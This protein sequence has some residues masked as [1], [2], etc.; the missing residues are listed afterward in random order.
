M[1]IAMINLGL[2][3]VRRLEG[4]RQINAMLAARMATAPVPVDRLVSAATPVT[5]AV[6]Y[7]DR[8]VTATG[9]FDTADQVVIGPE[10]DADGNPGW[11][12]ATPLVLA[13]GSAVVVNRGL[14]PYD[15]WTSNGGGSDPAATLAAFRPPAG[16]VTVTGLLTETQ[17]RTEGLRD[18]PDGRLR[19]LHRLDLSRIGHQ[20]PMPILP[21]ALDEQTS[22]SAQAQ[23]R[24]EPVPGPALNDGPHLSYA[25]Q[26]FSFTAITML[27]YPVLLRRRSRRD[28]PS[29]PPGRRTRQ[30][31]TRRARAR[32][33]I[34]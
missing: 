19:A 13:D 18:P 5:T 28:H 22:S 25:I 16:W 31:A 33:G 23:A 14:I 10:T 34:P 20:L 27:L 26:W 9:V 11:W 2:W 15:A 24:P 21:V 32:A 4:R 30:R 8:H 6:H 29:K 3:Q 12:L 17:N 7:V 1:V